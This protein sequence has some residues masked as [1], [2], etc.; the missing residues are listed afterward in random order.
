MNKVIKNS[1][2]INNVC[3]KWA[4]VSSERVGSDASQCSAEILRT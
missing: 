1:E 2:S 3:S 4:R